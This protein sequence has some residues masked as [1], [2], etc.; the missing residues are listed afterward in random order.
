MNTNHL[1]RLLLSR[2]GL[3]RIVVLGL[4]S[5]AVIVVAV[6]AVAP[7]APASP[8][9]GDPRVA[10]LVKQVKLLQAQVKALKR[11]DSQQWDEIGAG[12]ASQDCLGAQVADLIQGTWGVIDEI[13]QSTQTTYFGPQTQV[14]DYGS[15]ESFS[16]PAV[17]RVGIQSRPTINPLLPLLQWIKG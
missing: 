14:P 15:C 16:Q 3:T 12:W 17:P 5:V 2:H 8:G 7:V 11:Q 13:G 1:E 10:T 9:A 6:I 4:L